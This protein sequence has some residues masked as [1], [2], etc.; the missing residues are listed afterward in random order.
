MRAH[1]QGVNSQLNRSMGHTARWNTCQ[2]FV[3]YL[4]GMIFMNQTKKNPQILYETVLARKKMDRLTHKP[5]GF[6]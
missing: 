4:K 3:Q 2:D 6:R 1:T 5:I